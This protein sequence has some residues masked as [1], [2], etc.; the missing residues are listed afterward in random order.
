M[1]TILKIILATIVVSHWQYKG[2]FPIYK[3]HEEIMQSYL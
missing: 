3:E 2:E 1:E